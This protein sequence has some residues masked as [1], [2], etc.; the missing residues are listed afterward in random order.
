MTLESE[1]KRQQTEEFLQQDMQQLQQSQVSATT[2]M[3]QMCDEF[4][5]LVRTWLGADTANKL[6]NV[7]K[8]ADCKADVRILSPAD[9][10]L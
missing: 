5:D 8:A 3:K 10:S 2:D 7:G 9:A 4:K 6:F 1:A